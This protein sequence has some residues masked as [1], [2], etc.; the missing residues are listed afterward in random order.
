MLPAGPALDFGDRIVARGGMIQ[1]GRPFGSMHDC[2]LDKIEFWVEGSWL[3]TPGTR[4]PSTNFATRPYQ[5]QLRQPWE[6]PTT[7]LVA[8]EAL[9]TL[10]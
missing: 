2:I 7:N 4:L 1:R 10:S 6:L 8:L 9:P 3:V 5:Y